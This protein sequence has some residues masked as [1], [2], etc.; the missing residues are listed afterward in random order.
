[1]LATNNPDAVTRMSKG[2]VKRSAPKTENLSAE[3]CGLCK[4]HE[5]GNKAEHI[6][7]AKANSANIKKVKSSSFQNRREDR[8]EEERGLVMWNVIVLLTLASPSQARWP[9][10]Q[11]ILGAKR[12]VKMEPRYVVL[13][14]LLLSPRP[15]SQHPRD[16]S[17]T[18]SIPLTASTSNT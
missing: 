5:D 18:F 7:M 15:L 3:S 13:W 8:E 6:P 4:R 2:M 14:V 12:N 16:P 17:A 1:M 9:T 11:Y 10:K